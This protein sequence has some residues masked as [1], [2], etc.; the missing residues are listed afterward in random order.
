MNLDLKRLF[1]LSVER[2][3]NLDWRRAFDIEKLQVLGLDIGSSTVRI[4]QLHKDDTNYVVTA[5]GIADIANGT[6]TNSKQKEINIVRAISECLQSAGVQTRLAVC[7]VSGPEVAVR[8]FKFPSLPPEEA[9]G[10]VMLEASQVC[11]FNVDDSAVD[12]QLVPGGENNICGI[13]V[14]ATNKLIERKKQL[15]K[16][17]SLDCVLMD[18][19]GLALLNCFSKY[20]K[21]EAGR[22]TAILNIGNTYTTLAIM[23]ANA[24]P[25]IRDIACAGGTIVRDIAA[26]KD[27]STDA[28]RKTLLGSENPAGPE[29]DLGDSLEKGC[30]KLIVDVTETLRYYTAQEKSTVVEK[31]FVCGFAPVK[32]FVELLDKRLPART[33]LWNPLEKASCDGNQ[34]CRDILK[35]NGPEMVVAAGLAMRAV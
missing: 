4:I 30:Q 13:L 25:F 33:V 14:A 34:N 7:G 17:A 2:A 5:A 22:T 3:R 20:E 28:V 16:E 24:V 6:E 8:Y 1:N 15:V 10:A 31:I 23:G 21:T 19:D 12:Y 18:V 11:P 9:Q 26:E 35:K 32:R 27:V 29:I